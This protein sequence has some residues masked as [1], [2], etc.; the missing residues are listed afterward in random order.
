MLPGEPL[1]AG[2]FAVDG[3]VVLT[4]RFELL[5]F[6]GEISGALEQVSVVARALDAE[7]EQIE[8]EFT[9]GVGARHRSVYRLCHAVHNI[10][11]VVI[12]QDGNIRFVKWKD[13]IVTY[14]DQVATSVLDIERAR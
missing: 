6:G 9:D 7:G 3:A 12:S 8:E 13:G 1:I 5:G 11:A 14:W 4:K 10:I 2:L